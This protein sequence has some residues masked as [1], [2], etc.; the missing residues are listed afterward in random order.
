MTIK[1]IAF[2]A[3][4]RLIE[5]ISENHIDTTYPVEGNYLYES[6]LKRGHEKVKLQVYFGKKG[7]KT[8]VQGDKKLLLYNDV[9]DIV[10]GSEELN[11]TGEDFIEPDS[12]IGSDESGKGDFFGP[13]VVAAAAVDKDSKQQ[14]RKL[15]IKDSKE[16]SDTEIS[17]TAPTIKEI[18]KNRFIVRVVK[19]QE[20]NTLYER[21]L[22]L[23]RMLAFLHSDT[24]KELLQ[25]TECN[26][27][28]VDKFGNEK[29]LIA[30][31][32][33]MKK[34]IK[35]HQF[36]KG[37]RYIGVAAA[38]ILAREAFISWFDQI[39]EK[40]GISLPKGASDKVI[41]ALRIMVNK[42]GDE[43]KVRLVK[44][45]FKNSLKF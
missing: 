13:L 8:V 26:D 3:I 18:L 5:R 11:L 20:Y 2:A 34:K 16:Y 6:T 45:H 41:E 40:T 14:L 15:Y 37:E 10:S 30:G 17:S 21:Y 7:V 39:K 38:S 4:N 35:L 27:I 31:F 42:Y 9:M 32:S 12:Y 43:S 1:E 29:L 24:I 28:I 25:K 36:T 22:N 19:P 23:N 33:G 44:M